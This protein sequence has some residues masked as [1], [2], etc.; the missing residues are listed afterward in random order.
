MPIFKDSAQI[1][2]ILGE[3]WTEL[4]DKMVQDFQ[5]VELSVLFIIKDPEAYLY[6]DK[7]G[8]KQGDDAKVLKSTVVLTMTGDAVHKFW[9]NK[10]S[11]VKAL[12][13]REI[14]SKGPIPKVLKF[15][16]MV[17]PGYDIYKEYC[18]KYNLPLD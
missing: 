16:P 3:F 6:V 17:K 2:Q 4:Y 13:K 1:N 15:L 14:K 11:L 9:L 10:L 5:D 18:K 7:D 8:I 12:A